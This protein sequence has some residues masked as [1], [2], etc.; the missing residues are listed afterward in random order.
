MQTFNL[1]T[2]KMKISQASKITA[3]NKENKNPKE[4]S[5]GYGRE[6]LERTIEEKLD[7]ILMDIS[8]PIMGGLTVAKRIRHKKEIE[9]ITIIV[10]SASAMFHNIKE[11]LESGCNNFIPKPIK[12][13]LL[14][15]KVVE[16]LS[17]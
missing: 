4:L 6:A 5:E 17:I 14:R 11:V 16:Y 12:P 10:V 7:L 15:K 9:N 1:V 8:L 2:L 13:K 3:A